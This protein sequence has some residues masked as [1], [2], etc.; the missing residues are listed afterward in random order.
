MNCGLLTLPAPLY[1]CVWMLNDV[2]PLYVLFNVFGHWMPRGGGGQTT[3][4]VFNP[5]QLKIPNPICFMV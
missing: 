5:Q 4:A 3:S 2:C 1:I